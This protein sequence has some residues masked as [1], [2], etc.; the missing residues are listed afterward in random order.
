MLR[1]RSLHLLRLQTEQSE[2]E[3]IN[4][5]KVR[6]DRDDASIWH[7]VI[8]GLPNG[9]YHGGYYW[10]QVKFP[11][12]YPFDPPSISLTTPLGEFPLDTDLFHMVSEEGWQPSFTVGRMLRRIIALMLDASDVNASQK[13]MDAEASLA[14][15]CSHLRFRLLFPGFLSTFRQKTSNDFRSRDLVVFVAVGML[16]VVTI[17]YLKP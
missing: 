6:V 15:N 4:H 2:I 11:Q 12:Q 10:G 13:K 3:E 17:A 14:F 5:L 7:Y 1:L 8:F 9:P 16:L